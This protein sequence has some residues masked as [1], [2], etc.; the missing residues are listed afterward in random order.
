MKK[1]FFV[2]IIGLIGLALADPALGYWLSVDEKTGEVTAGW[3]VYRQ[4]GRLYGRILSAAGKPRDKKAEKCRESYPDFPA[5]GKVNEMTIVNTPWIYG[6]KSDR[7][8][9]WYGGTIIDPASGSQYQCKITY[10]PADGDRYKTDTLEMRGEIG[11][12]IGRSQYW[13]KSDRAA[14]VSL[15]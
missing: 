12:G 1:L 13:Q 9:E 4:D 2:F 3:E 7:P 15:K 8:G 11:F 10:R 6:L 5:A 14:A